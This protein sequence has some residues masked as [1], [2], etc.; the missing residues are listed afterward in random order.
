M[1]D[2]F[3][4]RF[5]MKLSGCSLFTSQILICVA[6]F[7]YMIDD[8]F[9]EVRTEEQ[10]TEMHELL[11]SAAKRREAEICCGIMWACFPLLL[12]ALYGIK[13]ITL[14]IYRGTSAE[15]LIYL[16]D[17]AYTMYICVICIILPAMMLVTVAYE[18]SFHEYTPDDDFTATG[19]YVQLGIHTLMIETADCAAIAD[20]TFLISLFLLPRVL[21]MFS[22]DISNHGQKFRKLKFALEPSC[23]HNCSGLAKCGVEIFSDCFVLS[24]LIVF[25]MVLF[26]FAESGFFAPT[27]EAQFLLFWSI[28]VKLLLGIRMMWFGSSKAWQEV[29]D[30]IIANDPRRLS[31]QNML[32]GRDRQTSLPSKTDNDAKTAL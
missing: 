23:C 10:V 28:L 30:I 22:A 26:A 31:T 16:A 6:S 18:W 17:K 7:I 14:S 21:L 27:G 12:I 29:R 32:S 20:A 2:T 8:D 11:S 19:Y 15:V 5:E 1:A 3:P 13:K 24:L 9:Y 25:C 4:S